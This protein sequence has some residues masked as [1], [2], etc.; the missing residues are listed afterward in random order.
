MMGLTAKADQLKR[1]LID[2]TAASGG[3]GPTYEELKIAVGLRSKGGVS[4]LL[5]ILEAR[6]HIR[7]KPRCARAIEVLNQ[8]PMRCPRCGIPITNPAPL[9]YGTGDSPGSECQS[10]RASVRG[11]SHA[12]RC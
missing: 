9:P 10:P 11:P 3:V 5:R 12:E 4:R 8:P 1:Y 7:R 2:Y 6:G